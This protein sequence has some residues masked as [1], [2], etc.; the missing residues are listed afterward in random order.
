MGSPRFPKPIQIRLI[1]K[2]V[3]AAAAKPATAPI[4]PRPR[5]APRQDADGSE[6]GKGDV[7]PRLF[8]EPMP[9]VE[10][11]YDGGVECVGEDHDRRDAEQS[12]QLIVE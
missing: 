7:Q 2:I 6:S 9:S 12:R 4:A 10:A 8:R 5:A 11:P 3:A 1:D